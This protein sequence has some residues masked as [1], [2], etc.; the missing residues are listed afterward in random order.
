MKKILFLEGN[1][2]THKVSRKKVVILYNYPISNKVSCRVF[3][4]VTGTYEIME[5]FHHELTK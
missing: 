1:I 5:F 3:N 4:E 2:Y